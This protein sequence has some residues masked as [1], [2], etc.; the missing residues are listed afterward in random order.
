ML[1]ADPAACNELDKDGLAPLHHAARGS[2]LQIIDCLLNAGAGKIRKDDSFITHDGLHVGVIDV[3]FD[4]CTCARINP[5]S[6]PSHAIISQFVTSTDID[7]VASS[8]AG[9]MTPLI[10]ASKFDAHEAC[11][12]L[13]QRG[14]EVFSRCCIGQSPLHYAARKGNLRVI[15][16]SFYGIT[17]NNLIQALTLYSRSQII[18]QMG[19]V[20]N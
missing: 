12:L 7:I 2:H 15:E 8:Q 4:V 11:R 18:L 14:A 19:N 5:A 17:Q 9:F 1:K 6:R 13:I 20:R 10:C 16:V 3:V